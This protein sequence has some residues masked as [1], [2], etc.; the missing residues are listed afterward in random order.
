MPWL[1][2]RLPEV[3]A[4]LHAF[5]LFAFASFVCFSIAG[6]HISLGLLALVI[7]LQIVLGSD[8]GE[9]T[10][11]DSGSLVAQVRLGFEWPLLAFWSACLIS[12]LLSHDPLDSLAHLKNLTTIIGA[13]AVA[14][15]LRR[16]SEWRT[17]ALWIFLST[18]ALASLWGLVKYALGMTIKVQG[19]QSTTMTWGAMAAMFL[20]LTIVTAFSAA[21]GGG[22]WAARVLSIPQFFALLLSFVRGAYVGL[23]AGLLYLLR[24][25]WQ[26]LLPGALVLLFIAGI[27]APASVRER[28]MSIF[29]RQNPSVQVRLSQWQIGAKIVADQPF[30][31]VGWH[32][33]APFTRQYA[34]PDPRLPQPVNDD[35]FHIGHYHNTYVTIAVYS[36]FLGLAAFVWLMASVWQQLGR[37]TIQSAPAETQ[38]RIW[39]CR[40]AL[41]SF[42]VNGFFDW[43]FGDAEVVTMFWFV[44]GLGLG[45]A[46]THLPVRWDAAS[47]RH[48]A[49]APGEFQHS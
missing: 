15:S 37:A 35:I 14:Y 21:N 31:G 24:R 47:P 10:A 34:Q 8:A 41:L 29:D 13:Y 4:R 18:A 38:A 27:V 46:G 5:S 26:R 7:I 3:L 45:Q 44:I 43:N 32:D 22:R 6:A 36:G 39:A 42:L 30:F 33:L 20:L 25:Q 48:E 12:S 23:A 17:P 40:A 9:E 2:L 19:T 1:N 16:H 49:G 28:V 11:G